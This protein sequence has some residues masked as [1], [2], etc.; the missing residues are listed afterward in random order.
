MICSIKSYH[1][2]LHWINLSKRISGL[3]LL[4]DC[5]IFFVNWLWWIVQ[6]QPRHITPYWNSISQWVVFSKFITFHSNQTSR[7]TPWHLPVNDRFRAKGNTDTNPS[8][9]LNIWY[10]PRDDISSLRCKELITRGYATCN[11][12]RASCYYLTFY[13]SMAWCKIAVSS[14]LTQWRY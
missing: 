9:A 3:A 1:C 11:T 6:T 7:V 14:L 4:W 2:F 10:S 13:I 5:I 12:I 8:Q